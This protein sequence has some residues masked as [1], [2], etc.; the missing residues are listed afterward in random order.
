MKIAFVYPFPLPFGKNVPKLPGGFKVGGGEVYTFNVAEKLAERGHKITVF[1]GMFPGIKKNP[2]VKGNLKIVYLPISIWKNFAHYAIMPSLYTKLMQEDFDII[3]SWQFP[4]A[5]TSLAGLTAK[6]KGVPFVVSHVGLTPEL[7]RATK[8]FSKINKKFVDHLVALTDYGKR[9]YKNYIPARKMNAIYPGIDLSL[10]YYERSKKIDAKFKG[11]KVILYTGRLIPSK[12]V[13]YVIRALPKIIEEV[14][15]ALFVIIGSGHIK[16]DLID[17]AE[18]LG[19]EDHIHFTGYVE[20]DDMRKYYSRAD[21][22]VMAPVYKDSWGGHNKEPGGF[23]LVFA[24]AMICN[25]PCVAS[26]VDTIPYWIKENV[27]GLLAPP[28]NEKILAQK[29]L[30][31]LKNKKLSSKIVKKSK[32]IVRA[33]YTLEKVAQQYEEVYKKVIA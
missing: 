23:G 26:T 9:Y 16:Q 14:P 6:T 33:K 27:N 32:E 7:S 30:K 15:N 18:K 11:K 3:H 4:T 12:G 17:L 22:F 5:Y 25:T 8:M 28:N 24:E 21:V 10:Y 31:L 19:V 13:D 29:I 20:D 1:T 2:Y